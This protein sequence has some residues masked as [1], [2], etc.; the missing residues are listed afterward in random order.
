MTTRRDATDAR[1]RGAARYDP[2]SVRHLMKRPSEARGAIEGLT[3][4]FFDRR[5]VFVSSIRV[6]FA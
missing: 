5:S 6:S 1:A 4:D 3:G 2:E